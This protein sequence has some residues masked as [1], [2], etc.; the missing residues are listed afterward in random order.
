MELK[1]RRK[2]TRPSTIVL[3]DKHGL[4]PAQKL[5]IRRR[6][7]VGGLVL[8]VVGIGDYVYLVPGRYAA[9]I[10]DWTLLDFLR[11]EIPTA[12]RRDPSQ[13]RKALRQAVYR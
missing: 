4:R 8:I 11:S 2:P 10:N 3:T 6:T 7:K 5:W 13:V 9:V 1:F 12:Q